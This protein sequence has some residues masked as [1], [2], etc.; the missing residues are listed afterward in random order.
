MASRRTHPCPLC[1]TP[2]PW[3]FTKGQVPYFHCRPCSFRFA[4]PEGNP[5]FRENLS[6]YEPAYRQYLEEGP[7]DRRNFRDLLGRIETPRSPWLDIGCGSGK[8]VRYLKEQGIEAS[9]LEP[10][11]PL[12][13]TYLKGDPS[14]RHGT[15]EDLPSDSLY[16]TISVIDVLE[17]L[18]NPIELLQQLHPHLA[19]EGTLIV[20]IPAINGL[21]PRLMGKWWPHYHPYHLSYFTSCSLIRAAETNGY[22]FIKGSW[23]GRYFPVSYLSRYARNFL[24]GQRKNHPKSRWDEKAVYLNTFDVYC[25]CFR[26]AGNS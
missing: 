1:G 21:L 3:H 22:R 10:A 12:F 9:G 18:S 4:T 16:Q 7:A 19:P 24:L 15:A 23:R 20:E 13:E 11:T 6:E 5:N 26:K 14:F 17:H 8:F 25:A 2:A